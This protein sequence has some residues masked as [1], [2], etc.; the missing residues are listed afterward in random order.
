MEDL[1]LIY[2]FIENMIEITD[3]Q[4]TKYEEGMHD[5]YLGVKK[6]IDE[7]ISLEKEEKQ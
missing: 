5:A 4:N 7:N 2:R 1:K 6:F 3:E